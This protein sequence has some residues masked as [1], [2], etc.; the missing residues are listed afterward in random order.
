MYIG[1]RPRT[2]QEDLSLMSLMESI[3]HDERY[4][5]SRLISR[6]DNIT[7]CEIVPYDNGYKVVI[8]VKEV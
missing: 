6:A 3:R 5:I 2:P 7:H 1:N 8:I 4:R